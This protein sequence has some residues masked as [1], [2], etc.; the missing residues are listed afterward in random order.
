MPKIFANIR[1]VPL[2]CVDVHHKIDILCTALVSCP[3]PSVDMVLQLKYL[4]TR[5]LA[6]ARVCKYLSI[7]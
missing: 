6:R 1:C 5:A 4:A 7:L 2:T 3:P